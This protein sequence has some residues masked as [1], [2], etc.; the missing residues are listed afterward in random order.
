M[1]KL[2]IVWY[3]VTLLFNNETK[4][5]ESG[6]SRETTVVSKLVST[7]LQHETVEP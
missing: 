2:R 4:L 6:R 7:V 5:E 3:E 1:Y